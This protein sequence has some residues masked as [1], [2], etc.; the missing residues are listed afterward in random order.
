L[1]AGLI[2]GTRL[3]Y[4]GAALYCSPLNAMF[5]EDR[6]DRPGAAARFRWQ[7]DEPTIAPRATFA[8]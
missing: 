3:D 8:G 2:T 6:T 1:W 5:Q 4:E 7:S